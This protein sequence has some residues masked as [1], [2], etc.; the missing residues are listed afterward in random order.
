MNQLT[1]VI[2]RQLM[3]C[4]DALR[5]HAADVGEHG[6]I[7][8]DAGTLRDAE[9]PILEVDVIHRDQPFDRVAGRKRKPDLEVRRCFRL[10]DVADRIET[11][12]P[13]C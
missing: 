11:P 2:G 5:L 3:R 9:Q 10:D 7:A 1:F 12:P 6:R 13:L 8:D 4:L